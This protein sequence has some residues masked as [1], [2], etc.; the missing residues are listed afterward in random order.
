[1]DYT[2]DLF[3]LMIMENVNGDGK[4][5]FDVTLALTGTDTAAVTVSVP[6]LPGITPLNANVEQGRVTTIELDVNVEASGSAL[7]QKGVLVTSD[8]DVSVW[9]RSQKAESCG[10]FQV[11]PVKAL[12]EEYYTVTTWP[13]TAV[14][15]VFSQVGVVA[16]QDN[17]KVVLDFPTRRGI[18]IDFDGD[19][20]NGDNNLVVTMNQYETLQVQD[21][22]LSDLTAVHVLADKPVAVFS[23]AGFTWVGDGVTRDHIVEQVT[24]IGAWGTRFF[25]VPHADHT[26]GYRIQVVTREKG[27]LVIVNG[28]EDYFRNAPLYYDDGFFLEA[29][30]YAYVDADKP[31]MVVQLAISQ[32]DGSDGAPSML[33]VAPV[34]QYLTGYAFAVPVLSSDPA[35]EQHYLMIVVKSGEQGQLR[36]NGN[37]ILTTWTT[38]TH[39]QNWVGTRISV[40]SGYQEIVHINN[41]PFL[42]STYGEATGTCAY[43]HIS[44]M[45]LDDLTVRYTL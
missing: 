22:T 43:G 8:E 9:V 33:L 5:I 3:I 18:E 25:V 30:Q 24:P 41:Q 23:G 32:P 15:S 37:P 34:E 35:D 7:E 10:G 1:M 40:D 17:T 12:K 36:L 2:G 21:E 4:I 39:A 29:D 44:G 26:D 42:A 19:E 31:V 20:Y 6:K 11:I 13:Q 28:Q 27:T 16:A 45:C 38:F 14:D